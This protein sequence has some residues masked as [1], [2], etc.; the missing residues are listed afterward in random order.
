MELYGIFSSRVKDLC[1]AVSYR[2][3]VD[4]AL[5]I[6]SHA[7]VINA[8]WINLAMIIS[9]SPR[10]VSDGCYQS[11]EE[12]GSSFLASEV[13]D[14]TL[15]STVNNSAVGELAQRYEFNSINVRLLMFHLESYC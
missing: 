1:S 3:R 13:V 5:R 6:E 9:D 12:Q 10:F 2:L 11:E 15:D 7:E 4:P 14:S 8:M